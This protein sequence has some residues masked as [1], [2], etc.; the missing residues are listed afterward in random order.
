MPDWKPEIRARLAGLNLETT[1]EAGM[2]EEIALH[3]DDRFTELLGHGASAEEAGQRVLDELNSENYLAREL[4]HIECPARNEPM[5]LG[6]T[7]GTLLEDF[8]QDAR[9]AARMLL[10]S[11]G[12]TA[13]AVLTLAIGIGANTAIFSVVNTVLLRPLPY[14]DSGRMVAVCES[15]P[16]LG[17][18]QYVASMGA[19]ADWRRQSSCFQELAAATVLGPSS[20]LGKSD[21]QLVHVAAVS[22]DFL[23]MLGIQPILGRQFARE[24]ENPDH[25]GVVLL[26]EG[27]W[28]GRFGA[29]PGVLDHSVRLGDRNFTVVG[30]MPAGVKLFDPAGVQGWDNG[31]SKCDLWRPLPVDSG[32][33]NQR[34]YRAFL[35]LG[36]LKPLVTL[37][38]AQNEMVNIADKAAAE[39]PGSDAG[40]AITVQ[41]WQQTVVRNARKP[42]VLLWSAVGLVLIIATA[43]LANLC[44]AR[45]TTR[46]KEFAIRT[47]LGAGRFRVARQLLAE[48]LLL[49]SLGGASGLLLARWSIGFARALIPANIPRADEINFDGPVFAF[50]SAVTLIV[51][52]LFGLAPLLT[53]WRR[54][55]NTALKAEARGSTGSLS[56]RRLR[57]WLVTSEVALVVILLTGA[58]LLARSFKRLHEVNPGFRPDHVFAMDL[59]IGSAALTNE[60]RRI[61]FVEQLMGRLSS[62]PGVESAAA[63]DGLPLDANRGKMDIALTSIDGNPP[64]TPDGK[65]LAGLR[66]VSPEYFRTMGIALSRGRFFTA[67]DRTN[68]APVVIINQALARRYFPGLNPVGRRI[69][70]PDF[71]PQ[72]CEIAGVVEDVKQT[73]LDASPGPEVF[74]PLLQECF[75]SVSIVVR[76][77]SAPAPIFDAIRREATAIE[78]TVPAYNSRTLDQLIDTS[79]APRQFALWLTGSLAGMALLLALVGIYGVLSC[80]V[81]ELTREIGL[82][83][84]LGAQR[85]QV[86]RM[87]LWRGMRSVAVGGAIGLAG[88][89]SLTRFL[90]GLLYEVS[91]SDSLIL[92]TVGSFLIVVTLAAC[93]LPAQRAAD[94]DPMEA[95]RC[96]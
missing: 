45:A 18:D 79:L 47:A 56:G 48:S 33:R 16:R 95:L 84:A 15:N 51:G 70:S 54:D 87:V 13:V 81:N 5:V 62:L 27:L 29:D 75:S 85:S 52:L 20:L 30:V 80:M 3:L 21:A 4:R 67:R 78:L 39:F 64:A 53:I 23:P 88:A 24:E 2:V 61:Q 57:A 1:K 41:P 40:W 86:L 35:V 59:S 11:P 32:L 68:T 96:E 12:F 50:T 82:R 91:P 25:S 92:V 43:N 55:V 60:L 73:A 90:R 58:G 49:S 28:R 31:F 71:G 65:L 72:L 76:A 10:N 37:A 36:R 46:Q 74:R 94:V 6:E 89:C 83:L 8:C 38:Q 22:A 93:W 26:S 7:K 66:L 69:G 14:K 42:L 34:S 63:V 9:H 17:L 19:Y 77:R 44:L